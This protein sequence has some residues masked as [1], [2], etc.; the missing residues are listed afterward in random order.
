MQVRDGTVE[1]ISTG[2]RLR[3]EHLIAV[4][5]TS[6]RTY[7]A[8][9]KDVN[10]V[11]TEWSAPITLACAN[12]AADDLVA[13]IGSANA[14]DLYIEEPS[15]RFP[16][17]SLGSGQMWTHRTLVGG[18]M[19]DEQRRDKWSTGRSSFAV[20]LSELEEEQT[21]LLHRFFRCLNGPLTPFWF[22][23][24][25]P[26]DGIT[27]RFVVRFR[28]PD[29]STDLFGVSLSNIELQLIELIGAS[30]GGDV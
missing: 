26:N 5:T 14:L 3:T 28:D 1:E 2:V 18:S 30:A 10:D 25:D 21:T 23:Y 20:T 16:D 9:V 22:E 27:E 17:L 6:S 29:I 12:F 19:F 4:G 8:A 7:R 11:W 13:S 24:T 15:L